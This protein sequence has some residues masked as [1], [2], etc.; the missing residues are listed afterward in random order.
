MAMAN[1]NIIGI[2][3]TKSW[4]VQALACGGGATKNII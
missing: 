3:V 2:F 4:Q 1:M